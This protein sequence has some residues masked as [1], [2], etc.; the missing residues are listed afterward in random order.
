MQRE[1]IKNK[2]SIPLSSTREAMKG[3]IKIF[4]I[5][6]LFGGLCECEAQNLVPNYSFET[7]STCPFSAGQIYYAPPWVD[8]TTTSSDYYNSCA[9]MGTDVPVNWAGNQSAKDGNAYAGCA[10]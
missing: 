9:S 10:L 8:P 5:L 1:T 3:F 6:I 2:G 7:F 4:F